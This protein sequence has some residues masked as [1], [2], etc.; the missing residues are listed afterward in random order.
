MPDI[1]SVPENLTV[2]GWLY[3]PFASGGRPPAPLTTGGVA[4][5]CTVGP[6]VPVL[7]ALSRHVPPTSASALSGPP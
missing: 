7:P 6:P 1:A 5:Y 2:S 3:Q 4:S